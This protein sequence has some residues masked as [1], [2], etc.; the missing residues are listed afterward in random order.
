MVALA[1]ISSSAIF[2]L[3]S[4]LNLAKGLIDKKLWATRLV[5]G[6]NKERVVYVTLCKSSPLW[7]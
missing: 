1:Q 5:A 7:V 2:K 6:K 3:H 4:L